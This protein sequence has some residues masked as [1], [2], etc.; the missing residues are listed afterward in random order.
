MERTGDGALPLPRR[1]PVPDW[2][3]WARVFE[4]VKLVRMARVNTDI[5]IRSLLLET[6]FLSFMFLGADFGDVT[7]RPTRCCCNSCTSPPM[8]WTGS[9]FPAEALVGQAV[10]ARAVAVLRRAS[11]VASL[12]GLGASVLPS[13]AFLL[14]GADCRRDGQERG[15]AGCRAA[16]LLLDGV[17]AGS[18]A[19]LLHVR[20]YLHRLRRRTADMRN[21][22]LVSALIYAAAAVMLVPI[23]GNHGLVDGAAGL[24]RRAV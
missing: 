7:L 18:C 1:L 5:L 2:R 15:R 12:W 16:Y 17:G 3:D 24:F 13:W 11:V 22:M 4:R 8:R 19:R 10:G 21:M 14:R 20:R 6:I 23:Y 9:P